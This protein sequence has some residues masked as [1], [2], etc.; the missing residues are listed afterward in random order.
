MAEK[1]VGTPKPV[2][3]LAHA[4]LLGFE[5]LRRMSLTR[6]STPGQLSWMVSAIEF[7]VNFRR[8]YATGTLC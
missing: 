2:A 5:V 8:P 6:Y 1:V 7:C 4:Q 3:E